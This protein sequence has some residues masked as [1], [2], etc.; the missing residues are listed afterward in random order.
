MFLPCYKSG[1][2][3]IKLAFILF[4]VEIRC[5]YQPLPLRTHPLRLV[6][7]VK[8]AT[9]L[10]WLGGIRR[11]KQERDRTGEVHLHLLCSVY[12]CSVY[13]CYI[14]ICKC[15]FCACVDFLAVKRG[16]PYF[17]RLLSRHLSCTPVAACPL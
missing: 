2:F 11:P 9:S 5:Q 10:K 6:Q 15:M 8:A 1:M 14:L 17:G 7:L 4:R 13:V 16:T 12:S 3:N